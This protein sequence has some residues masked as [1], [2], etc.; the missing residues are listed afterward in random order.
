L[1][2]APACPTFGVFRS[3]LTQDVGAVTSL[4]QSVDI[5][6]HME[7]QAAIGAFAALAQ[8]TRL[9]VF[10]HLLKAYPEEL[11]AGEIARVCKVPHN[12]MSTHLAILTRAKLIAVR[13]DGRVMNYS[14]NLAGLREVMKFL[15]RDC[16]GGRPDLCAPVIEELRCCLPVG[17]EHQRVGSRV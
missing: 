10:Q 12:T 13:R 8:S 9:K 17:M 6:R 4:S 11:P 16:C 1:A 15:L 7:R 2:S 5:S 14:A 3:R